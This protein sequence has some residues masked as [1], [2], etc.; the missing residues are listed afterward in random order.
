METT[1]Y[2]DR[3]RE[4]LGE[5]KQLIE[6]K[7]LD[8]P[9]ALEETGF[10]KELADEIFEQGKLPSLTEFLGLC[11]IAG[12]PFQMPAVETPNTPM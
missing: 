7:G 3:A 12:I 9:M 11:Q 10:R 8:L 5:I 2:E 4:I 1:V 6:V